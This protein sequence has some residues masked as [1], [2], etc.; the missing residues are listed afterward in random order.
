MEDERICVHCGESHLA[1]A[2]YER[3]STNG[4]MEYL[5][6]DKIQAHPDKAG[7]LQVFPG[8]D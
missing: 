7:W 8:R 6:G 3:K 2:W 1:A 4:R 5:C